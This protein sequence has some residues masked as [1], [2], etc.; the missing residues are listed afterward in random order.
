MRINKLKNVMADRGNLGKK[1]HFVDDL[2]LFR[3]ISYMVV[4]G[5]ILDLNR[6][7]DVI[8]P[9]DSMLDLEVLIIE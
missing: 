8:K 4:K 6:S 2:S 3:D 5:G 1:I 9:Y 7:F